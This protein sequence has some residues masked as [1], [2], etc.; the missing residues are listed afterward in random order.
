MVLLKEK[1]NPE[2]P[3]EAIPYLYR[4]GAWFVLCRPNKRPITK[5]WQKIRAPLGNAL[6]H[7]SNDLP[8]GLI[9]SSVSTSA[10]DIDEG[11]P[12]R[13]IDAFPPLAELVSRQKGGRHLYYSDTLS[14][15]N[16][17]FS[18]FEC[19][20]DI[21]SG[22]G[23]LILYDG[24]AWKLLEGLRTPPADAVP[25]PADL[26]EAAGVELDPVALHDSTFAQNPLRRPVPGKAADLTL[27]RV[28][29]GDQP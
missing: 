19:A 2:N 22:K 1:V 9:P 4:L 24:Q 6:R 23:Y 28:Y 5:N 14:R 16:R 10:L 27:E 21:R 11:D 18:A 29:P 15:G 12:T 7:L 25:F 8:L 17:K 3:E 13:M 20:G 26:F